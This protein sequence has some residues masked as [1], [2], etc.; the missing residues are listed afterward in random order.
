MLRGMTWARNKCGLRSR[1]SIKGCEV[2][3][4]SFTERADS[5]EQEG[6]QYGCYR[7]GQGRMVAE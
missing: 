2:C 7:E 1:G 5:Q 3:A 6:T 4:I